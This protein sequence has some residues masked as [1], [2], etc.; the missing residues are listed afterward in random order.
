VS[1][2]VP[3]AAL[4]PPGLAGTPA[5]SR[6]QTTSA[7]GPVNGPAFADVLAKS[8]QAADAPKFSRHALERVNQRGINVDQST[9]QR[10]AGG[11][12]R[13]SAKGSNNAVV[14]VDKTAFVVSVPNNTVVTAVDSEHMREHVF[15]NIDSAVLA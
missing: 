6:P 5:V 11:M 9:L 10:L 4:V 8:T 7:N 12:S 13:A 14:F 3:N 2:V 1:T 15:T